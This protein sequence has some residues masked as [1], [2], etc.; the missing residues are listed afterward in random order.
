[1][2][3]TPSRPPRSW[4][5][6]PEE[7]TRQQTNHTM[8]L[9]ILEAAE[10]RLLNWTLRRRDYA[11]QFNTMVLLAKERR[12]REKS[13]CHAYAMCHSSWYTSHNQ[14]P[15]AAAVQRYRCSNDRA[16]SAYGHAPAV[17]VAMTAP[18]A[19]FPV[20]TSCATTTNQSID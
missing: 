15:I 11:G 18:P 10:A 17:H 3:Y 16:S 12:F 6:Q 20:I 2:G 9:G 1:M 7:I 4:R 5:R 19:D 14:Q 8:T 13:R